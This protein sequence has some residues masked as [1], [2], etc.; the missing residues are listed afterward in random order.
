MCRQVENFN[1]T[2]HGNFYESH[3]IKGVNNSNKEDIIL[4]VS[5]ELE[6]EED[7]VIYITKD[8]IQISSKNRES[9]DYNKN[10]PKT[11]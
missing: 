11:S 1:V 4:W 2:L 5:S 6:G 10:I 7:Y 8:R 3:P 9:K